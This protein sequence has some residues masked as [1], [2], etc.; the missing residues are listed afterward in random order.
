M[1]CRLRAGGKKREKGKGVEEKRGEEKR[2][3]RNLGDQIQMT[4]C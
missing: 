3:R 2:G 1:L 4:L